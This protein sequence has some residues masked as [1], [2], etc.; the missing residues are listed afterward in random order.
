MVSVTKAA[1]LSQRVIVLRSELVAREEVV[2]FHP[3]DVQ[4]KSAES[5]GGAPILHCI[6]PINQKHKRHFWRNVCNGH[7]NVTPLTSRRAAADRA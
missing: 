3:F 7:D 2:C 5:V 1:P 4:R 6:S